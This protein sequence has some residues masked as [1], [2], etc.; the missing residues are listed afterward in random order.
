MHEEIRRKDRAMAEKEARALLEQGE[1]GI[2][3]TAGTDG[4][5][6]GTPLSYA[7]MN[8]AI[9][10]HCATLGRKIDNIAANPAVCFTVVGETEP[11]YDSGFSTY[12]ASCMV[13]GTVRPVSDDT[14][15]MA[16]LTELA[17]KYLPAHMDK[18]EESIKKSWQRTAVYAVSI[19]RITGKAKKKPA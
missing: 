7:V 2:L 5:P 8:G 3:A 19:D 16:A 15:K 10:I 18:A 9:Y 17:R 14:E 6:Y 11:V 12:Y 1:Y 13:F 4:Q